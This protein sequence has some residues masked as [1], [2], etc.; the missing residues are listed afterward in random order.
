MKYTDMQ[1]GNQL[2]TW[3]VQICVL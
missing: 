3:T 2:P 1:I